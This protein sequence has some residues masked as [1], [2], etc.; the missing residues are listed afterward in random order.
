VL[1]FPALPSP[2]LSAW[3]SVVNVISIVETF[4]VSPIIKLHQ[5]TRGEKLDTYER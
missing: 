4:L 3:A 2:L 1:G 5:K